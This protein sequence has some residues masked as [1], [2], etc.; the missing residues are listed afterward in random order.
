MLASPAADLA[1]PAFQTLFIETE[2]IAEETALLAKRRPRESGGETIWVIHVL[3]SHDVANED[4]QYESNRQ[5]FLG[6]VVTR[7][8]M[9][10]WTQKCD[11]LARWA[12]CLTPFFPLRCC[13]WKEFSISIHRGSTTWHVTINIS[14]AALSCE[15]GDQ[16]QC[17]AS[18][19]I[20]LVEDGLE[21]SQTV[22]VNAHRSSMVDRY[23]D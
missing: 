12:Q 15:G 1:H 7:V 23:A 6:A 4:V 14:D 11:S 2:Y 19:P 18:E 21:H 10:R 20:Q 13:D 17:L 8:L 5:E 3:A 16:E 9:P 22:F